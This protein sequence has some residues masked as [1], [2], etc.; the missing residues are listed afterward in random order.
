MKISGDDVPLTG[1]RSLDDHLM[2]ERVL[3]DVVMDE[4]RERMDEL[5]QYND[6]H[7]ELW[8]QIME[9]YKLLNDEARN[10]LMLDAKQD[11]ERM[12]EFKCNSVA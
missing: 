4:I 8:W 5:K 3:E 6:E 9:K 1:G 11:F 2:Q 7:D 10:N 12:M